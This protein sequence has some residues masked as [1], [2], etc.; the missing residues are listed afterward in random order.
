MRDLALLAIIAGLIPV[1]MR[2]PWIGV[3][4]GAWISLMNPHRYAFGFANNFPFAF[5]VALATVASLVFGKQKIEFPRHG[6]LVMII[7]LMVW[8]SITLLFALEP[9]AAF[10]QWVNVMKVF[11]LV[12]LSAFLI[13]SRKEIDAFIWV[14]VLSVGFFGVKGGLFTIATGGVHKV[15]G[16]PGGSY[17]S[18]NNAI[19]IALVMVVPLMFYL[20][21]TANRKIIKWGLGAAALLSMVAVLG[22]QSRGALL[23]VAAMSVFLWLKSRKKIVFGV[24]LFGSLASA[25][26][27]MPDVW[28]TRMRSMENYEADASAQGRINSWTMAYNLANARPIVGGGFEIYTRRTFQEYAP[29][30]E[31]VHSAHSIYFQMLGE[32]GYVGLFLFLTLGLM[33]WVTARRV[34]ARSRTVPENAWAGQLARSIQVSLIGFGV[35]GAFVNISYWELQYYELVLLVAAYKLVTATTGAGGQVSVKSASAHGAVPS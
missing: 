19:C 22:S 21:S 6:V 9:D 17:V 11:L 27:F 32:H 8:F 28:E 5:I 14:L 34:I 13:R 33:G 4:V 10:A 2:H 3:L 1:I 15:Y 25:V 30:P 29:N 20:G 16:P 31:D 12:L 7:L 26:M 23:A 18:D 35:G 24:I